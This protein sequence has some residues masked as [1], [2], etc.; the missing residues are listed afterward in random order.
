MEPAAH[1]DS[2]HQR[3][4]ALAREGQLDQ[5]LR[6]IREHL[7]ENPADA[8]AL[9]DAG[10]LLH[11]LDQPAEALVHFRAALDRRDD[12]PAELLWNL[13]ECC[14]HADRP[15]EALAVV[16]ELTDAPHA[17]AELANRVAE[18]CVQ[19]NDLAGATEAI[20]QSLKLLPDQPALQTLGEQLRRARL[21]IALFVPRARLEEI[22]PIYR[23]LSERFPTKLCTGQNEP[24]FHSLLKWCDV[25]W[26]EGI[27]E[28]FLH[29]ATTPTGA[30]VLC[31]LPAEQFTH[32]AVERIR[33]ENVD[34]LLTG[35]EQASRQLLLQRVPDL[36]DRTRLDLLPHAV[37]ADDVPFNDRP[38][39]KRLACLAPLRAHSNPM[40]LLQH[41][42]ALHAVDPDYTLHLA[43]VIHDEALARYLTHMIDRLGLAQA[44]HLEGWQ[45]DT[46][47]WLAD[48]HFLVTAGV[49][50]E[51]VETSCRA[52]AAG[53][54][55]VAHRFPGAER[56]WP[57]DLLYD[58][59]GQFIDRIHRDA[60]EPA[61][62][63]RWAQQRFTR[64]RQI[65]RVTAILAEL[66]AAHPVRL[67]EGHFH[68]EPAGLNF[69]N[70]PGGD[71][72]NR[73]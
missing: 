20:L 33:W 65:A 73:P 19:H 4:L 47:A 36:T 24:E 21:K 68:A 64:S 27:S 28:M 35:A 26:F 6:A 55:L 39:G 29:A 32:P 70:T 16:P 42:A 18:R 52:L 22:R 44:V 43:G 10:V 17:A 69:M 40:G 60:Y 15:A 48:K 11:Q 46:D 3:G 53:V 66:E 57:E 38:R 56:I 49:V 14:M 50:E 7:L 59:A 34:R 12:R 13:A 25:A 62:Y 63:R 61:R 45:A 58:T 41:F 72:T 51:D 8:E 2:A 1:T 37:D 31:H 54:K 71:R 30:H 67:A 23:F 9:N 5:A